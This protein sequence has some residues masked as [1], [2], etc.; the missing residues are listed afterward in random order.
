MRLQ[1]LWLKRR[2]AIALAA[3]LLLTPTPSVA[4]TE[5]VPSSD[6]S[7][8]DCD[9]ALMQVG[10]ILCLGTDE[11]AAEKWSK[12]KERCGW[13]DAGDL[14]SKLQGS[15]CWQA[16]AETT[17]TRVKREPRYGCDPQ[18]LTY[19]AYAE[20]Q[21]CGDD[22]ACLLTPVATLQRALDISLDAATEDPKYRSW[23]ASQSQARID[24][25][26]LGRRFARIT[27][28]LPSGK[29]YPE[30]KATL[31]GADI[32][33]DRDTY[34]L[35]GSFTLAASARGFEPYEEQ[36]ELSAGE[37]HQATLTMTPVEAPPTPSPALPP[38][39]EQPASPALPPPQVDSGSERAWG[40]AA[41]GVG[42]SLA[43]VGLILGAMAM[44]K[45][46]D[47]E[48][49]CTENQCNDTGFQRVKEGRQLG[50]AADWTIGIGAALVAIGGVTLWLNPATEGT[51]AATAPRRR[52]TSTGLGFSYQGRF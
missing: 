3:G 26:Q 2:V 33:F 31:D 9:E 39:E 20:R 36:V 43:T 6:L 40:W 21:A 1:H 7:S 23:V 17:R 18:M 34:L 11:D 45:K 30:L 16:L 12:Q 41:V 35:P 27:V 52:V 46:G 28:S 44:G 38:T 14:E 19:Q 42:A 22:D 10:A 25:A 4:E 5:C 8:R 50:T 32:I 15:G 49:N 48:S 29:S 51:S 37:Q 13:P 24:L 47:A